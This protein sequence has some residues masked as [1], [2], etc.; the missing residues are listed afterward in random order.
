[1]TNVQ[2]ETAVFTPQEM[3][4]IKHTQEPGVRIL[5]YYRLGQTSTMWV[6]LDSCKLR[7]LLS[8]FFC[9]SNTFPLKYKI[10]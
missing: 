6:L 8:N 1:M 3:K 9:E 10:K 7:T 5:G 2:G 4:E